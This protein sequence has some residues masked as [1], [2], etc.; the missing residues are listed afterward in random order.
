MGD[1]SL[2]GRSGCDFHVGPHYR[3]W[4]QKR[5][6]SQS[7][8]PGGTARYRVPDRNELVFSFSCQ[9][10]VYPSRIGI[11]GANLRGRCRH[12]H[13]IC[14]VRTILFCPVA[15]LLSLYFFTSIRAAIRYRPP[16]RLTRV[17]DFSSI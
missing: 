16:T 11:N 15:I 5:P 17:H 6:E 13:N 10:F 4:N 2:W 12:A 14:E 7:E 8:Q 9:K 3:T 1:C